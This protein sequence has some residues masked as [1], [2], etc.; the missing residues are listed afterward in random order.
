MAAA[1]PATPKAVSSPP[2]LQQVGLHR[3]EGVEADAARERGCEHRPSNGRV[4]PA[5]IDRGPQRLLDVLHGAGA[6]GRAEAEIAHE[7]EGDGEG[8]AQHRRPQQVRDAQVGDLRDV[9]AANRAAE[10]GDAVH[11]LPLRQHAL[12]RSFEAGRGERVDEPGLHGAREERE[13]QSDADGCEDPTPKRSLAMPHPQIEQ[14]RRQQR[15]GAE[16]ERRTSAPRVRDDARRDLE[17]HH[18]GAERGVRAERSEVAESRVEQEQRVDPPDEGRGE[19]VEE[20]QQQ[21]DPLDPDAAVDHRQ[22][23]APE[24]IERGAWAVPASREG[25]PRLGRRPCAS[26]TACVMSSRSTHRACS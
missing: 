22:G 11:D 25:H 17:Q 6:T 24:R 19:G 16:Q 1:R 12:E 9:P 21:I 26:L 15:R 5:V 2:Q 23:V 14:G 3:E 18:A 10:H 8:Q 7:G 4:P 13:A 20:G